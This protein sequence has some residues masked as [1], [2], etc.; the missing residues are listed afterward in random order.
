MTNNPLD[1]IPESPRPA[2]GIW[3]ALLGPPM[4]ALLHLQMSYALEHTACSTGTKLQLH[5]WTVLCLIV[6]AAAGL[7][8]RRHW[9]ALGSED[10]GQHPGPVGTLRLMSLLGMIGAGIFTLFILAQWF[11]NAMLPVCIQT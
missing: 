8:A 4:A 2:I 3:F 5:I 7:V 10:P 11:P 6:V 1:R 9:I